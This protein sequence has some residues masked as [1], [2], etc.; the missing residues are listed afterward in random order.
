MR[1]WRNM[2]KQNT[3]AGGIVALPKGIRYPSL[4]VEICALREAP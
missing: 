4:L 2:P 1:P 3:H